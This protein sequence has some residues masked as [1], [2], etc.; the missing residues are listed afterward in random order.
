MPSL[1]RCIVGTFATL[2]H[3][4]LYK[5]AYF[6]VSTQHVNND[7]VEVTL[8]ANGPLRTHFYRYKIEDYIIVPTYQSLHN[9]INTFIVRE[10]R[11]IQT[12]EQIHFSITIN[13][14]L[15]NA[16]TKYLLQ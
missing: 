4:I 15:K 13:N 5:Y 14:D 7:I 2:Y 12:N 1:S 8:S 3:L 10:L 6:T 16:D 11:S 9:I